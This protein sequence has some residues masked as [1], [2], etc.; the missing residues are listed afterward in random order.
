M[1]G[2]FLFISF[3]DIFNHF[4]LHT[5]SY[6]YSHF[7]PY[8]QAHPD[9]YLF[10]LP[11]PHLHP[12]PCLNPPFHP[13]HCILPPFPYPYHILIC[14]SHSFPPTHTIP[15]NVFSFFSFFVI[16]FSILYFRPQPSLKYTYHITNFFSFYFLYF[17]FNSYLHSHS[18]PHPFHDIHLR[19]NSLFYLYPD[20]LF[21]FFFHFYRGPSC[22][23]CPEPSLPLPFSLLIFKTISRTIRQ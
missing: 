10:H 7:Y 9:S 13:N 15:Y 4:R 11:D 22:L 16:N 20:F 23:T 19:L 2:V 18:Y 1:I 6:H 3:I 12:H 5:H 8:L 14:H 21:I 17:F